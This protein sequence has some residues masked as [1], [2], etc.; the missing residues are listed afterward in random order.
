[1]ADNFVLPSGTALAD[2]L[3]DAT[4]GAGKVQFVKLMDGTL[5]G[6]S[7]ASVGANGLAVDVKALPV[8]AAAGSTPHMVVSLGNS[9]GKAN[10]MQTGTLAS[11]ATTAD[12]VIKTYTVTAG[13]TLYL[14]YWDVMAR[15]T[16]FAAT[17]TLFGVASLEIVSGTKVWSYSLAG[18]GCANTTGQ[19]MSEPLVVPAGTV[20]RLVTTPAAATAMTWVG[21]FGGYEK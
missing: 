18:T 12:Q 10:V 13:K 16:T 20:I 17:A 3:T 11:S 15:L 21:N 19:Q 7:K 8:L 1:M 6:T 2:E 4:L 9:L 14:M 5:D